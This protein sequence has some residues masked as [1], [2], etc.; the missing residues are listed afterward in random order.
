[1]WALTGH[2]DTRSRFPA[3]RGKREMKAPKKDCCHAKPSPSPASVDCRVSSAQVEGLVAGPGT[4]ERSKK[5]T[6]PAFFDRCANV[7]GFDSVLGVGRYTLLVR[8]VGRGCRAN[9]CDAKRAAW[10]PKSKLALLADHDRPGDRLEWG[11]ARTGGR[12]DALEP[13]SDA[14][15]ATEGRRL[16]R[17]HANCI[18]LSEAC[19]GVAG[20]F[21]RSSALRRAWACA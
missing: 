8:R 16:E 6:A 12:L 17:E 11:S 2:G 14:M 21:A 3:T 13:V 5:D 7:D 20:S 10:R 1:M 9:P 18:R 19:G 4:G 15:A